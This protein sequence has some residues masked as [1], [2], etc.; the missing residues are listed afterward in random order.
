MNAVGVVD[1]AVVGDH[2]V[3]GAAVLGDE[4]LLR[5]PHRLHELGDQYSDSGPN[6]SHLLN[7]CGCPLAYGIS[8]Q[9]GAWSEQLGLQ[10]L[11]QARPQQQVCTGRWMGYN[12]I[13]TCR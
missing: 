4:D 6:V 8:R 7:I 10:L 9:P 12:Y 2:L 11:N 1:L 13:Q 3:A 5:L